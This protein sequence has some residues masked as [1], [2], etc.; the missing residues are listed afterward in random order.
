[1]TMTIIEGSRFNKI[2][3]NICVLGA[4]YT[5]SGV[6]SWS[7]KDIINRIT[8]VASRVTSVQPG[9][10]RAEGG[11]ISLLGHSLILSSST[12]TWRCEEWKKLTRWYQRKW[13]SFLKLCFKL[14]TI[15]ISAWLLIGSSRLTDEYE[16]H[17][18]VTSSLIFRWLND[19]VNRACHFRN[20]MLTQNII[21][22]P[23]L[24]ASTIRCFFSFFL[25]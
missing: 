10:V 4:H 13:L 16:T 5:Y 11:E 24:R 15:E 22:D 12:L 9:R 2:W 23:F 25:F 20:S 6:I 19:P 17:T 14:S 18:C 21:C 8:P 3:R 1:M 7:L